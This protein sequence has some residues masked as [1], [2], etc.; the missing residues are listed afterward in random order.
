MGHPLTI[1]VVGLGKIGLPIAA[2][3]A[4]KGHRVVGVDS[5]SE[6]V[7][8]VND[9]CSHIVGEP[10]LAERVAAAVSAGLLRATADAAAAFASADVV[11]VA[12]PLLTGTDGKADF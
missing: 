11:V 8:S 1:A 10:F 6:V 3:Y 2:Q 9:G 5:S 4:S 12:V 7:R